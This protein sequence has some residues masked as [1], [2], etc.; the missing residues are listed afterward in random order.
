MKYCNFLLLIFPLLLFSC[1]NKAEVREEKIKK[2]QNLSDVELPKEKLTEFKSSLSVTNAEKKNNSEFYSVEY[3]FSFIVSFHKEKVFLEYQ[4]F[5][6]DDIL[7]AD[8]K[9]GEN[10]LQSTFSES[11]SVTSY[12]NYDCIKFKIACKNKDNEVLETFEG[13]CRNIYYPKDLAFDIQ[14]INSDFTNNARNVS[15]MFS[16]YAET[17]DDVVLEKVRIIPPSKDFYWDIKP[18][19]FDDN[20][21]KA[22]SN[23]KDSTH[24]D[25]IE[26]GEYHI[27]FFFGKSGII[28]D[29]YFLKDIYGNENGPNYGAPTVTVLS[30]DLNTIEWELQDLSYLTEM[31]ILLYERNNK[32]ELVA[33]YVFSEP[34]R[35]CAKKTLFQNLQREKLRSD[36]IKFNKKYLYRIRLTYRN[37]DSSNEKREIK[38]VSTSPF[39]EITFYGFN[40]F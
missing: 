28:Q 26:C 2:E 5:D 25:Y 18:D 10:K 12:F 34:V 36:K 32:E 4:L 30:E 17:T 24:S 13:E 31:E 29:I 27:Q 16:C 6:M 11:I 9:I 1:L 3:T 14:S 15:L 7:L 19:V 38:Y 37:A 23:I 35:S 8:G 21:Y 39:Y 40:L 22:I 20:V 33:D